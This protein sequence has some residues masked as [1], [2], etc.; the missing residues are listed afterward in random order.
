[1][2][3]KG[4]IQVIKM[5]GHHVPHKTVHTPRWQ[6]ETLESNIL[7]YMIWLK[8]KL[9]IKRFQLF[10]SN[11]LAVVHIH[12][13][14]TPINW[15]IFIF[16]CFLFGS[17]PNIGLYFDEKAWYIFILR[18]HYICFLIDNKVYKIINLIIC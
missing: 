8:N 6:I 2:Q 4:H 3:L 11:L 17:T 14:R 18:V 7:I 9:T 16:W 15:V 5:Q 12:L 1:M 10:V 13:G